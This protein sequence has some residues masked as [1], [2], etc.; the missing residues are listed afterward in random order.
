MLAYPRFIEA[1][2]VRSLELLEID[3]TWPFAGAAACAGAGWSG[4]KRPETA[5]AGPMAGTDWMN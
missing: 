2:Q 1:E 3:G 5:K 4:T